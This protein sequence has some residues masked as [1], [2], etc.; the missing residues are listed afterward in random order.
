MAEHRIAIQIKIYKRNNGRTTDFKSMGV[1]KRTRYHHDIAITE[2]VFN[3]NSL[4]CFVRA[5]E[6]TIN[7]RIIPPTRVVV[8][9]RLNAWISS[10]IRSSFFFLW[11]LSM[12]A[13]HSLIERHC[14]YNWYLSSSSSSS[15]IV[16]SRGRGRVTRWGAQHT[17]TC[18]S[19]SRFIRNHFSLDESVAVTEMHRTK[20]AYIFYALNAHIRCTSSQWNFSRLAFTEQSTAAVR[21]IQ[22]R[23]D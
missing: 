12:G 1:S 23:T 8:R 14:V 13:S 20:H 4:C 21:H 9:F 18:I 15:F 6:R 16:R 2:N 19:I 22:P 3:S 7:S 5:T 11:P 17:Q 10:R